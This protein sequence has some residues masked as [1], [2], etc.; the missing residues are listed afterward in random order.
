VVVTVE[1]QVALR[2]IIEIS[3]RLNDV[4]QWY[5]YTTGL[6]RPGEASEREQGRG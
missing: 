6:G 4:V 5:I 1:P 3:C 2:A